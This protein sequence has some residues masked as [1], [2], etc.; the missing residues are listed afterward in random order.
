MYIIIPSIISILLLYKCIAV[1]TMFVI[2]ILHTLKLQSSIHSA[3]LVTGHKSTPNST[4]E[5]GKN[6]HL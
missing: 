6:A 4:T 5:K 3:N 2:L 1:W